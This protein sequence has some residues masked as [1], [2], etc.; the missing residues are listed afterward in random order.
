MSDDDYCTSKAQVYDEVYIYD[1]YGDPI[2]TLTGFY[3]DDPG[4][5]VVVVGE[6]SGGDDPPIE[7]LV[8]DPRM[9]VRLAMRLMSHA[10][11]LL[12]HDA[13]AAARAE[14]NKLAAA[15]EGDKAT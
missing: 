11:L 10:D 15:I 7:M 13:T 9:A 14:T 5:P 2:S 1:A 8:L 4:R 12:G 6:L 3:P